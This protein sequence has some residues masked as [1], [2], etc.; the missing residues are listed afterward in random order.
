MNGRITPTGAVDANA[1]TPTNTSV[2]IGSSSSNNDYSNN[3]NNMKVPS[4][5]TSSTSVGGGARTGSSSKQRRRRPWWSFGG[6]CSSD[7]NN[8]DDESSM[9]LSRAVVLRST[10]VLSL[11]ASAALC[12]ALAYTTLTNAEVMTAQQTYNSIAAMALSNA[13]AITLRKLQGSDVMSS[14]ATYSNPNTT[15]WPCIFIDGFIPLSSKVASLG[16]SATQAYV[17]LV[18]PDQVVDFERHFQ[19]TYIEEGRPSGSGYSDFGFG[20]FQED[21]DIDDQ[22]LYADRRLHDTT[23]EVRFGM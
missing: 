16:Q 9:C 23:G 12:A 10:L 18:Q 19:Q 13:Q 3:N 17:I 2:K 4:S 22:P 5:S 21:P 11:L 1:V 8:K 20:I 7:T 6:G 15:D 14:L